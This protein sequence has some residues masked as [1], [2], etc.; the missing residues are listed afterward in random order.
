MEDHDCK[1]KRLLFYFAEVFCADTALGAYP[2]LGKILER[3]TGSNAIIGVTY[4]RVI[5]PTANVAYILFHT[6]LI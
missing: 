5:N 3:S 1:K 4:C 2:I 6:F